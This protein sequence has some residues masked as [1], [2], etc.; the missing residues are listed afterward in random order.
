MTLENLTICSLR[1]KGDRGKFVLRTMFWKVFGG[2]LFFILFS[3]A[4]SFVFIY[5][6]DAYGPDSDMVNAFGYLFF[7]VMMIVIACFV[8]IIRKSNIDENCIHYV[9]VIN[10]T[11]DLWVFN[12]YNPVIE[13]MYRRSQ[14]RKSIKLGFYGFVFSI[15][16]QTTRLADSAKTMSYCDKYNIIENSLIEFEQ[17]TYYEGLGSPIIEVHNLKIKKSYISFSTVENR[18]EEKPRKVGYRISRKFSNCDELIRALENLA[19]LS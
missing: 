11:S 18:L 1:V 17:N 10:S 14:N 12:R 16:P 7:P 13:S 9:F 5:A 2:S 8:I 15:F 3:V 6:Q 19:N 4:L